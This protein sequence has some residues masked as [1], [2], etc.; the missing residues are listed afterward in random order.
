MVD[1][2]GD[3]RE[4]SRAVQLGDVSRDGCEVFTCK[5]VD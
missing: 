2:T 4:M 1:K 5:Y 3:L